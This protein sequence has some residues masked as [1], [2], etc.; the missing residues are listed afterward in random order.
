[1]ILSNCGG[2]GGNSY[3][4]DG[5]T[6]TGSSTSNPSSGN[7]ARASTFSLAGDTAFDSLTQ[8]SKWKLEPGEKLQIV[9]ANGTSGESV[10]PI[11]LFEQRWQQVF[12]NIEEYTELEFENLGNFQSINAATNAGADLTLT[13][14]G[15]YSG[16]L[17]AGPYIED[18]LAQAG[19]PSKT[20]NLYNGSQG[21]VILNID[22]TLVDMASQSTGDGSR[23]FYILTHEVG[24]A[25]GLKHPHD[26]GDTGRPIFGDPDALQASL[27]SDIYTVMSYN[28]DK[29]G[30]SSLKLYD[31]ATFMIYDTIALQMLYGK[32]MSANSENTIHTL[33]YTNYYSTIW[34]A[35]GTDTISAAGSDKDWHLKRVTHLSQT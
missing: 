23:F 32:H 19:F 20:D 8:G 9:I 7:H 27:D 14:S 3:G 33:D 4:S 1:M 6:T 18:A 24:H 15:S 22:S 16:G 17:F 11:G 21:D 12:N 28:P 29:Y 31:P 35:G 13:I 2:G 34:D 30:D 5:K 26:D 25:M 10:N